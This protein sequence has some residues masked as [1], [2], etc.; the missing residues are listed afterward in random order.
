MWWFG[1]EGTNDDG[2]FNREFCFFSPSLPQANTDRPL[3][4][5][6]SI[7]I[8]PQ[9]VLC[10]TLLNSIFHPPIMKG[11]CFILLLVRHSSDTCCLSQLFLK[12]ALTFW[13]DPALLSSLLTPI[14]MSRT[15]QRESSHLW[16]R[17]AGF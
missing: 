9:Q 6:A 3:I 13:C 14:S 10:N 15:V 7:G 4:Y 16:A 2:W 11:V 1:W 12:S 5:I 17:G 8:Q